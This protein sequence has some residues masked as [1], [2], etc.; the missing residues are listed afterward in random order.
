MNVLLDDSFVGWSKS[1]AVHEPA[2]DCEDSTA[3]FGRNCS[4]ASSERC[5]CRARPRRFWTLQG[6]RIVVRRLL[7]LL[8]QQVPSQ[9][10]P[11]FNSSEA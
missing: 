5:H 6:E 11:L 2:G 4:D 10:L 1:G 9:N 8:T 7:W 3:G